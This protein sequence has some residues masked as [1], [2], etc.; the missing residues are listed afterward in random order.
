MLVGDWCPQA[1]SPGFMETFPAS[2]SGF[3]PWLVLRPAWLALKPAWP[4]LRP[5]WLALRPVC[6]AMRPSWL[7]MRP[8]WLALRPAWL[9]L[10]PSWLSLMPSWLALR[11]S[12]LAL[13]PVWL[14]YFPPILQTWQLSLIIQNLRYQSLGF[15][16]KLNSLVPRNDN[17]SIV[18]ILNTLRVPQSINPQ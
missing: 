14:S 3:E 10:R 11:P 4:T 16:V 7:A 1:F 13:S 12:W 6:L 15:S 5:A 2:L 9:A 17:Q 18:L 8:A